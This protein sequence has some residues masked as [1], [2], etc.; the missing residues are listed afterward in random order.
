MNSEAAHKLTKEV[1]KV[2]NDATNNVE[3]GP[4]ANVFNLAAAAMVA[5]STYAYIAWRYFDFRHSSPHTCI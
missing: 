1:Q 5:V 2:F 3:E 4:F